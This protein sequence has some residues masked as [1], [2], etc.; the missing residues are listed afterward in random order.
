V[1][2]GGAKS[3]RGTVHLEMAAAGLLLLIAL[4]GCVAPTLA[5]FEKGRTEDLQAIRALPASEGIG[6]LRD[7]VLREGLAVRNPIK[8]ATEQESTDCDETHVDEFKCFYLVSPM[9]EHL[10]EDYLLLADALR[11]S[12]DWDGA[13]G[14]YEDAI[15]TADKLVM[16]VS[17]AARLRSTALHG[18]E[19]LWTDRRQ[20]S[21][22]A[23]ARV[24]A[25]AEDAW[26]RTSEAETAQKQYDQAMR[27]SEGTMLKEMIE[28]AQAA[29]TALQASLSAI[30]GVAQAGGGLAGVGGAAA[31]KTA[32]A[33]ALTQRVGPLVVSGATT[34]SGGVDWGLLLKT[35]GAVS[36]IA[37]QINA[38]QLKALERSESGKQ[39][40]V[41][42]VA[43]LRALRQGE[44]VAGSQ[45]LAA[46]AT[47]SLEGE[48]KASHE[49]RHPPAK[50]ETAED[51]QTQA[52]P[53]QPAAEKTAADP[54]SGSSGGSIEARLKRVD[55]LHDKKIIK[56]D[57]WQRERQRILRDL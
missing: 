9:R 7:R 36:Q 25:R 15:A 10:A 11:E 50:S 19:T 6:A 47:A 27:Q 28:S 26:S 23:A 52:P 4:S 12:G 24:M 3:G 8:V 39:A 57:E 17:A 35:V 18:E 46:D 55:D 49:P 48:P 32:S 42:L 21:R 34:P 54:S 31:A 53:L 41:G 40:L 43:S 30:Q 51:G 5:E 22:A 1:S 33:A 29:F 38:T 56:D 14:A 16:S 37:T 20:P 13:L 45:K 2:L 44:S